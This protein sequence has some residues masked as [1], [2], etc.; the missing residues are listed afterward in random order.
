ML[1]VLSR[2]YVILKYKFNQVFSVIT[3][4]GKTIKTVALIC[5]S[6]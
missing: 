4:I 6:E 5:Y 2:I 3:K 1:K